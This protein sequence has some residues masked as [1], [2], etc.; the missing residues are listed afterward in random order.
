ML[1]NSLAY[2]VFLPV[3]VAGYFLL[4]QRARVIWLLAA[5]CFFYMVY[6]AVYVLVLAT[7]IAIDYLAALRIEAAPSGRTRLF[8]LRISI[9]ATCGVLF[10]FKYFNFFAASA[11]TG[12][13]WLGLGFTPS[14]LTW[15][16][17]IGLSFHTFQSLAYV[18]EV[19]RGKQ[20]AERNPIVYATYVMFFPQLVAGPIERP[21]HLLH[22]FREHHTFDPVTATAGIKRIAWGLFKKAVIA[23]RLALI[24]KDVFDAPAHF[25]GFYLTVAAVA[26]TYQIYC[27]FSGYTDIALGSA[28]LL[29]F[30]LM[31]NFNA[32][33][34]ARSISDFWHR[35]HISLS[36][37]FR[38]YVYFP[39]GGSRGSTLQTFS[40]LM[41]TFI[42]SGLWHGAG[43]TY[44]VWGA[45]NGVYLVAGRATQAWRNRLAAGLGLGED[46]PL[47]VALGIVLTFGFTCAAFVFFRA[48]SLRQ[49]SYILTHVYRNFRLR[50]PLATPHVDE[51]Q[52]VIAAAAI[53]LLE[54]VQWVQRHPSVATRFYAAPA[55]TR[56]ACYLAF[57][58]GIALFG[59]YL[60]GGA[61]IYFQF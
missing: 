54:A 21:Q 30:R 42:L 5:S 48:A 8:Y 15:A 10:I 40:N 37:W 17:P 41:I 24:V 60:D 47:R 43:W 50:L 20:M 19:Y 44:L 25:G 38:D 16:L 56:W 14:L 33:F 9:A 36:T 1:F 58:S 52:F 3:V 4:P 23:D 49:A 11:S 7:L 45:L 31:E 6:R 26:F 51:Q 34:R 46:H 39:L 12:A 61:F 55:Q 2:A 28:Q 22:Q 35:W 59:V 53:L 32:P 13:R 18:I 29:R 57:A 27:D